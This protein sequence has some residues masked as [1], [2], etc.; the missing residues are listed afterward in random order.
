MIEVE[1]ADAKE[2]LAT[3]HANPNMEVQILL[4]GLIL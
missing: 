3:I 2:I 1:Q 4:L